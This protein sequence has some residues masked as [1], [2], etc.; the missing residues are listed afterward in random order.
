MDKKG[1]PY[2]KT[3][4]P[5][6]RYQTFHKKGYKNIYTVGLVLRRLQGGVGTQ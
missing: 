3:V 1:I 6:P 4:S 5:V 2:F